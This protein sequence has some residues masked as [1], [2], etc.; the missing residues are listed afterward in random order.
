MDLLGHDRWRGA[1]IATISCAKRSAA[2]ACWVAAPLHALPM[3]YFRLIRQRDALLHSHHFTNYTVDSSVPI[4]TTVQ[5]TGKLNPLRLSA[6]D[7]KHGRRSSF[8]TTRMV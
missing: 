1:K 6:N 7:Q 8:N 3:R 2:S 5:R 4:H